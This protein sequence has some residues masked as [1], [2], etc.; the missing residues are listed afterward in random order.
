MIPVLAAIANMFRFNRPASEQRQLIDIID[1]HFP[2]LKTYCKEIGEPIVSAV[3]NKQLIPEEISTSKPTFLLGFKLDASN[4]KALP[5][6]PVAE[7]LAEALARDKKTNAINGAEGDAEALAA[8]YEARP[9]ANKESRSR[10]TKE[11]QP[12][13][14]FQSPTSQLSQN[15]RQRRGEA[16]QESRTSSSAVQRNLSVGNRAAS[17]RA[18]GDGPPPK[19]Q[20]ATA[21]QS[22]SQ[23]PSLTYQSSQVDVENASQENKQSSHKASESRALHRVASTSSLGTYKSACDSDDDGLV[24]EGIDTQHQVMPTTLEPTSTLLLGSSSFVTSENRAKRRRIS[25]P[26]G[27][28]TTP[29]T[30]QQHFQSPHLLLR[31]K[32]IDQS[33]DKSPSHVQP[34]LAPLP[35]PTSGNQCSPSLWQPKAHAAVEEVNML[36]PS[37]EAP[38]SSLDETGPN[39]S[40][41]LRTQQ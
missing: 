18:I 23:T 38:A 31:P 29:V 34:N 17:L 39:G 9:R 36:P 10:T 27:S 35:T 6:G 2:E 19:P 14:P 7:S 20:P 33:Y 4:V 40:S 11:P 41:P 12:S 13:K 1:R 28:A 26:S 5:E 16:R 37:A 24:V 30:S 21:R 32:E 3:C 25:T 22:R 8:L 15:R